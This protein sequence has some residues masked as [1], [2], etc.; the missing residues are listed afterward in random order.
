MRPAIHGRRPA[1]ARPRVPPR[2]PVLPDGWPLTLLLGGFPLFWAAGVPNFAVQLMAVPMTLYL[3]RNRPIKVPRGFVLWLLFLTWTVAGLAVLGVNPP[4]T[5]VDSTTGRLFGWGLR[6]SSYLAVTIVLLYVGNLP[7]AVFSRD[8]IVRLLG[9][10]FVWTVV[11]G[12]AGMLAPYFQF[13]SPFE[14]VLPSGIRNNDYVRQLAHPTLAQVQD[15]IGDETPRPAAPFGYTNTWGYH[16]T[17]LGVWFV[18][19]WLLPRGRSLGQRVLATAVVG[20]GVIVLIYS[21]N[22][23]AWLG[24]ALAMTYVAV[25]LALRARFLPLI[26]MTSVALVAMLAVYASPLSG[27]V[28]ARL[29][30]GKSNDIRSFTTERAM[31]LSARSPIIGYGSTR[32]AQGSASSIAVGESAECPNCGNVSIGINGYFYMLLMSTGWVGALFFLGFGAVQVWLSRGDAAPY[33]VAGSTVLVM[34]FFYAFSYDISTWM[35]IP[36]VTIG[37]MWRELQHRAE[38]AQLA[39][40]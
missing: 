39:N 13:T 5:L 4:G 2:Y 30:D 31:E 36:A 33:L 20:V 11:G 9:W 19:G 12:V 23:A 32:N 27:V 3:L 29:E 14:L 38:A 15:L 10:L 22:R 7:E 37:V 1:V 25:R 34:T 21:L 6:E 28:S 26:V 35:L 24:V 8:R 18:A 17:V 40:V 16:I